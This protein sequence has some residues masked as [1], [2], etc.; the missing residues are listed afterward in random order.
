LFSSKKILKSILSHAKLNK[1]R[2]EIVFQ[3]IIRVLALG[4]KNPLVVILAIR[5]LKSYSIQV[6]KPNKFSILVTTNAIASVCLKF[7]I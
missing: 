3:L 1:G 6:C 4:C 7:S 2:Q 5:P